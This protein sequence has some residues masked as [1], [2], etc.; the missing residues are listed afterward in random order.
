V[1]VSV[2]IPVYDTERYVAEAIDSVLAQIEP[3]DEV[4]VVNDGSTD[5]TADILDGFGSRI[6]LVRQAHAGPS[7]ALNA[8]IARAA[9]TCIAFNDADDLWMPGKLARQRAVLQQNADIEAVFGQVQQFRSPDWQPQDAPSADERP[10]QTGVHRAAMLIRRDAFGRVGAFDASLR[11]V[12]FIDWYG[13]AMQDGLR[14]VT[15]TDIVLRRR[16]HATNTGRIHRDAQRGE[17][18]LVLK[19]LLDRRRSGSKTTLGGGRPTDKA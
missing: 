2:V 11:V 6:I 1:N 7:A 16:L 15:L 12:D 10:A 3:H 13:R 5:G 19:R 14:C 4:I 9:G 18:I 8:G 17:D